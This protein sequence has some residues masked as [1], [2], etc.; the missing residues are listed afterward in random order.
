[1]FLKL[2]GV[3][4]TGDNRN[5]EDGHAGS[6]E[7]TYFQ[8]AVTQNINKGTGLA[9]G[10]RVHEPIVIRKPIDQ[11]TPLLFNALVTNQVAEGSFRFYRLGADNETH[12]FYT[13]EIKAGRI[14]AI[15]EV[16]PDNENVGGAGSSS[17][18]MEEVSFTFQTIKW[19]FEPTAVEF[20]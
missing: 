7:C 4:V 13:V 12:N 11:S 10:K 5:Q 20:Q 18:P 3:D 19:R 8:Y 16:S 1:L 17:F 2:N 9:Q 14:V 6:I 15:N